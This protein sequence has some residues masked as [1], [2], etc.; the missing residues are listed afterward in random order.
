VEE[1]LPVQA[2]WQKAR[3]VFETLDSLD[4]HY[5]VVVRPADAG[6]GLDAYIEEKYPGAATDK[7]FSVGTT[8]TFPSTTEGQEA[9]EAF[10]RHLTTGSA[11]ELPGEF[12]ALTEVPELL[13]NLAGGEFKVTRLSLQPAPATQP[14]PM[15]IVVEN[16]ANEHFAIDY[17]EFQVT[18]AGTDEITL[19][20][21]A[22]ALPFRATIIMRPGERRASINLTFLP[23]ARKNPREYLALLEFERCISRP[24]QVRFIDLRTNILLLEM[25]LA[26]SGDIRPAPDLMR[27]VEDLAIIQQQ[28]MR[29]IAIPDRELTEDELETVRR[30]SQIRRTGVITGTWEDIRFAMPL[31]STRNVLDNFSD[32]ASHTLG[33]EG[34]EAVEELF[35]ARIPLGPTRIILS[36]TRLANEET[37]R[38]QVARASGGDVSIELSFNSGDDKACMQRFLAWIPPVDTPLPNKR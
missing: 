1:Y 21:E 34:E 25:P 13:R 15:R 23:E 29:P 7:P 8:L 5:R 36:D 28:S 33:F 12:V 6:P 31:A 4:S 27:V 16:E 26:V 35:G 19:K 22:K 14:I 2:V 24:G 18:Q 3:E 30:L 9:K 17:A 32:G 38:E 10:E 20:G 11:V 37:V